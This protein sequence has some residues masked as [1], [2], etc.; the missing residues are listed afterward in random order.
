MNEEKGVMKVETTLP[1][2]FDGTF[3]FTN[4]SDEDFVGIWGGKEYHFPAQTTSPM[5]IPEHSPLEV[6][7]IRKQFAKKL[8]EREYFKSEQMKR[9]EGQERPNNVPAFNSIHQAGQYSI[10][11]LTPYIQKCLSVLPTAQATVTETKK[12][13]LEE[14]LSRNDD[15]ELNTQAV[16]KKTSLKAKALQS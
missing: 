12:Q 5:I 9:F 7:Q 16:D 3:K 11:D 8:A 1:E 13:P 14:K 15:G 6:Q 2:N 10:D 4:P